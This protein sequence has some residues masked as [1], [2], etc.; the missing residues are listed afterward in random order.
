MRSTLTFPGLL[1]CGLSSI[2]IQELERTSRLPVSESETSSV[3]SSSGLK[4]LRSEMTASTNGIL[5]D[6]PR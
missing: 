3:S 5:G 6:T 2:R 1:H 4:W